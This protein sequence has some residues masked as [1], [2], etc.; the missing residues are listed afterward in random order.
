MGKKHTDQW[1]FYVAVTINKQRGAK[2]GFPTAMWRHTP[3]LCASDG[4]QVDAESPYG[5][6][7]PSSAGILLSPRNACKGN[8]REKRKTFIQWCDTP[9]RDSATYT[10][11]YI[12]N[13]I[14]D[15]KK[16]IFNSCQSWNTNFWSFGMFFERNPCFEL[17]SSQRPTF[18]VR[19]T[20]IRYCEVI[21]SPQTSWNC[22]N[23]MVNTTYLLGELVAIIQLLSSSRYILI[24]Q[25]PPYL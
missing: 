10:V 25:G 5:G 6:P 21:C 7:P 24:L 22:Q 12:W 3:G 18:S 2:V 1:N 23:V 13:S 8:L 20:L 17:R 15:S 14:W 4:K 11:L 16:A 19:F 9:K